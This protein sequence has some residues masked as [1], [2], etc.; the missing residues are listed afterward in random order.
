M[1]TVALNIEN[2]TPY[3]A[4]ELKEQIKKY[5]YRGFVVAVSILLLLMLYSFLSDKI[6]GRKKIKKIA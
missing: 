4:K 6:K 3:G 1:S 2:V 5:T